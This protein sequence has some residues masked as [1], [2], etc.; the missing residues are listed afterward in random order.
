MDRRREVLFG[1]LAIG[2]GLLSREAAV[3]LYHA[4]SGEP[5]WELAIREGSLPR[6]QVDAVVS[7][8]DSGQL[9]CRGR[10]GT[11]VPLRSVD[12]QALERC[13]RCGG[14]VYAGSGAPAEFSPIG[15]TWR[16]EGSD[17]LQE[18][19]AAGKTV[20]PD[21]GAERTAEVDFDPHGVTLAPQSQDGPRVPE[22]SS[23]PSAIPI[24]RPDGS[25]P[26]SEP[27]ARS[28]PSK[29]AASADEFSPFALDDFDVVA[30]IGRGGMG[31]VF[32][33]VHRVLKKMV[34][35]KVLTTGT[36]DQR[37]RFDREIK[38]TAKLEHPNI[39]KVLRGGVVSNGAL[40]GR[41]YFAMEYIAGRDLG[42]WAKETPGSKPRSLRE[43]AD[44][45]VKICEAIHFAHNRQ[46]IHRDLKPQNVLVANDGDVPKICDFGL[47][48]V[49]E[50]DLTS[51][52]DVMGTPQYMPPE[53][54]LGDRKKIGPP[55]DVYGL[56]AVLY[57]CL[58]GGP[59]F[60]AAKMFKLTEK[61]IRE[62][63]APP[64]E[65]NPGVPP[66]LDAVVLKTLEKDPV[67][68]YITARDLAQALQGLKLP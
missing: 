59:P 32:R 28:E 42:T 64:S 36:E 17:E 34:A 56:G 33:G 61:V 47:A 57:H 2:R 30:P 55:T 60:Q 38:A 66:A 41:P 8:V 40:S 37:A 11:R 51:T 29:A 9:V 31:S 65:K 62:K 5:F 7:R 52:G 27:A 10:C 68:R 26:P 58:T 46:I 35:I 1:K 13:T 12:T 49:A 50:S 23:L 24:P 44:M 25:R 54:I 6:A 20:A 53:Q 19:V 48:K 63:T 39:V 16:D 15:T 45:M 22:S 21:D 43:I 18:A 67:K 14:P 3:R 4:A